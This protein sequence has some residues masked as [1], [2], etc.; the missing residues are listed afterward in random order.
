MSADGRDY[1]KWETATDVATRAK[2][3]F[4]DGY[5]YTAPLQAGQN[6]L[7]AARKLRNAVAHRSEKAQATF[8]AVARNEL[9]GA[10]PPGLTVGSFLNTTKP[11][12]APPE[13]FLE[14]YLGTI[15]LVA[16]QIIRP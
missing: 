3:F 14:H 7:E 9:G 10:L 11:G 6:T 2:R 8:E 1:A 13:S 15:Q 16:E 5:P 12:S 4:R